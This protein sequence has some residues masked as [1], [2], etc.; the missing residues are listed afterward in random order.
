MLSEENEVF[1][2]FWKS[3]RD[4]QR[5]S[6]R[7]LLIGMSGGFTIGILVLITLESGW[8]ERATMVANSR[9]SSVVFLIAI[10]ILSVFMAFIYRKF[11][12]EMNEQRY[13]EL[14][15]LKNKTENKGSMQP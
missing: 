12:W 8:Y 15:S 14:M 10:L 13:L 5:T 1:L 9:M 4:K 2:A 11:R 7:P 6:I 3:N